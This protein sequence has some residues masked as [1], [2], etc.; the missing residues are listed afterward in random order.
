M[1]VDLIVFDATIADIKGA[2]A[3][4]CSFC[5]WIVEQSV[6]GTFDD[7]NLLVAEMSIDEVTLGLRKC[8][9]ITPWVSSK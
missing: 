1:P 3:E 4:G 5:T 2:A 9:R 7:D 8:T 6:G